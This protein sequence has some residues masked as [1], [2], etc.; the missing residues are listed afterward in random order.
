[1][2]QPSAIPSGGRWDVIV[3]GA[4][5]AGLSAAL[6]LGRCRRR[7]LLCDTGTPRSWA[8]HR[9]HGFLTRDG[10]NLE[11]FRATAREQLAS[12]PGVALLP[13]EVT[14][15]EVK[16]GDGFT[17]GLADGSEQ[18]CR[19][20]LLA[21]GVF[22]QLPKLPNIE[23]FFGISVHPCPYCEGWEMRDRPIAVYGKGQRGY[24]MARAMTAWSADLVLCTDGP[25]SLSG[26]HKRELQANGIAIVATPIVELVGQQGKLERLRFADG[27][28]R[29]CGALF[30][31]TPC[32]SQSQLAQQLGCR[33]TASGNVHCGEYE[34][35]SVPGVYAAGNILKDVQLSIVA[36][37]EG[38][39]AAFGINR[40]LTRE[41]FARRAEG[42]GEIEGRPASGRETVVEGI[43][44]H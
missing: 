35:S 32:Q 25:V 7:V 18:Q 10:M 28:E 36:A 11:E 42:T 4:G 30:F 26:R 21:S 1:M 9:M 8:A 12:Y 23:A 3:V 29:S 27:S 34:A 37:A 40:A 2:A 17:V 31:D 38:A 15:V 22:D 5:P 6:I 13:V 16:T 19:K 20:L 39:R 41:D 24:E 33:M 44:R 43:G 14:R